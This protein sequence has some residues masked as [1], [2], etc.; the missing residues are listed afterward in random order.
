[1][2]FNPGLLDQFVDW[3]TNF[4]IKSGAAMLDIGTSELF[5]ADDPGSLN[6]FLTHFGAKPYEGDELNRMAN[7]AFAAELFLQA[8]F[9]YE[10]IDIT[11]YPH[12]MPI[13][14]NSGSLPFWKR[15]RYAL[16]TNCGTTEHVLNQ[17]NAFKLI[18]DATMVGGIM[19]HGVPM[20]GD[21]SHGFISYN[22][23]FFFLLAEANGY[24]VLRMWG[25]AS[26]D[27]RG[28]DPTLGM[29]WNGRPPLAPDAFVHVLLR[30]CSKASF[31]APSDCVGYPPAKS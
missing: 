23:H 31:R 10:A 7:R 1:M 9:S 12:T 24:E 22:P 15:R 20:C 29:T 28:P 17:Y 13:D 8:G 27:V 16:V 2:G 30:R 26:E 19:Y 25:W 14:L 11:P 4:N 5:C 18:H 6:R 3:C 21:F